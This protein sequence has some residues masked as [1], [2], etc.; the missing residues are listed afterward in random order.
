VVPGTSLVELRVTYSRRAVPRSP[1]PGM[2]VD[3]GALRKQL[4]Q[5]LFLVPRGGG[6]GDSW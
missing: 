2:P 3:R 4:T 5:E 6:L 1:L